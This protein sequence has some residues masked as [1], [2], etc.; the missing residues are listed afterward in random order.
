MI[1]NGTN[2]QSV[3]IKLSDYQF[4]DKN[5]RDDDW[6]NIYIDVKSDLGNWRNTDPSLTVSEFKELINWFKDLSF[7]KE[8]EYPELFFTEPN[9]GFEYIG[10]VANEKLIKIVFSAESKPTSVKN[11]Q[12]YFVNFQFSNEELARIAHDLEIELKK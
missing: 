5:A 4:P 11:D 10:D 9:L 3:E 7:N 6:L 12:E 2:N 1:L 8:V